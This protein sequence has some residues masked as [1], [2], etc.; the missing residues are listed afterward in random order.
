MKKFLSLIFAVCLIF[1]GS[2]FIEACKG[3]DVK[4]KVVFYVDGQEYAY[5]ETNGNEEI[6]LPDAP[7]KDGYAFNG[8][9]LFEDEFNEKAYKEK[10]ITTDI[11]VYA[12]WEKLYSV[13]TQC[14][15]GGSI[16]IISTNSHDKIKALDIVEFIIIP[17]TKTNSAGGDWNPSDSI[18]VEYYSYMLLSLNVLTGESTVIYQEDGMYTY[19][20]W[21]FTKYK[22]VMPANDVSISAMIITIN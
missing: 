21:Q 13:S 1:T 17:Q 3:E 16:H 19:N 5:F 8:W 4:N 12:K 2:F 22:F 6:K 11:S 18:E 9:Y 7:T 20:N 15:N 14:S 10:S